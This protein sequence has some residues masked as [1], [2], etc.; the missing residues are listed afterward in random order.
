MPFS[1]KDLKPWMLERYESIKP[2]ITVDVGPGCGTYSDLMRPVHKG[3]WKAIEAWGPYITQY[4]LWGKYDHVVVSD[5]RHCDLCSIHY[6]PNLVIM[7]DVLEH[8]DRVEAVHQIRRM[9]GWSDHLLIAIPVGDWPQG[10]VDGVWFEAHRDTWTHE[11]MI[12]VLGDGTVAHET[13]GRISVFHW[14]IPE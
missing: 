13:T 14:K 12:D 1:S 11:E 3:T 6:G 10:V 8:M 7:G 9:Q 2:D 5:V 4:G